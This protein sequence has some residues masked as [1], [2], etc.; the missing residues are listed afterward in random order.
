VSQPELRGRPVV[1]LSNNDGG[2]IARSNE[3][4]RSASRWARRG[5]CTAI[6]SKPPASS[7]GR[8]IYTLYGDMSR[9]V[10][11]MPSAFTPDL[12]I[13]SI[14]E[15]FLGMDGFGAR[16]GWLGLQLI[17]ELIVE[18]RESGAPASF[19]HL[20]GAGEDRRR[21]AMGLVPENQV[22]TGLPAGG[23]W[24]RTVSTAVR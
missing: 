20:V 11:E 9:R 24:I 22:R 19:D 13:Y 17:Q 12:E 15:A 21:P 5:T 6:T 10:M 16:L 2:V 18:G 3:A 7:C 1:V 14:D 8:A 4:R 23:R